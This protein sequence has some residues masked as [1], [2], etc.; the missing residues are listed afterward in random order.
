[1]RAA[2]P[3]AFAAFA[4]C[5]AGSVAHATMVRS[6]SDPKQYEITTLDASGYSSLS[7]VP[8]LS[9]SGELVFGAL[10]DATSAYGVYAARADGSIITINGQNLLVG[11]PGPASVSPNGTVA[12]R[13]V[14]DQGEGL[15]RS[16]TGGGILITIRGSSFGLS[17]V[18]DPS[19]NNARQLA[20]TAVDDATGNT[21]VYAANPDGSIITIFGENFLTS[22]SPPRISGSGT[23]AFSAVDSSGESGLY[24]SRGGGVLLTIKGQSFG[25][26]IASLDVNDN[27]D[28]VFAG[29]DDLGAS[30]L[31]RADGGGFHGT[32][33]WQYAGASISTVG[34]ND[35]GLVA[36][37]VSSLVRTGLL[38]SIE[39]TDLDGSF[40]STL[41]SVGDPLAGSTVS[42]LSFGP[43]GLNNENQLAF[44]ASLSDGSS[45]LFIATIPAPGV[46]GGLLVGVGAALGRRRRR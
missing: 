26:G 40:R 46:A 10:D 38:D 41:I 24:T 17:S 1:M 45:S 22:L 31:F 20:F 2:P 28:V 37:G 30:G 12:F 42:S 32:I 3:T 6:G 21:G 43:D 44:F 29:V 4:V 8:G 39:L 14:D 13:G 35:G 36:V 18:G 7:T 34:V 16:S 9:D 27:D 5:L 15:Y 11:P 25:N 33:D 19:T 23:A